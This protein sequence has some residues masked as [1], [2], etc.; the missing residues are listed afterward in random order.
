MS[1]LR[2]AAEALLYVLS[3][4]SSQGQ[5]D[6][7]KANLAAAVEADGDTTEATPTVAAPVDASP[8]VPDAAP[9]PEAAPVVDPPVASSDASSAPS[10]DE[11]S[12]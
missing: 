10:T 5:L 11:A 4:D 2:S 6:E 9:A 12:V 3:N 7:A 1:D 8:V